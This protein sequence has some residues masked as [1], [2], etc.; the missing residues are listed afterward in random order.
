MFAAESHDLCDSG[1]RYAG[2]QHRLDIRYH[3]LGGRRNRNNLFAAVE[4]PVEG[5]VGC[6]IAVVDA[7]MR[8]EIA[9]V[10]RAAVRRKIGWR[11]HCQDAG[12]EKLA[13]GEAL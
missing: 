1:A 10:S 12:L 8:H 6:W 13:T 4:F 9:G 11:R 5:P 7:L 2:F 3:Q